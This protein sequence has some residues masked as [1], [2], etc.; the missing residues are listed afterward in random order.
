MDD[1]YINYLN[2]DSSNRVM[3]YLSK[4]MIYQNQHVIVKNDGYYIF[5]KAL[6]DAVKLSHQLDL[7][8][9]VRKAKDS[10]VAKY[11]ENHRKAQKLME[12]TQ[13]IANDLKLG[14]EFRFAVYT[15]DQRKLYFFYKAE[16]RI[17]FREL[18][19]I[20]RNIYKSE[21]TLVH[22]D[23]RQYV[24]YYGAIESCGLVTCCSN[25]LDKFPTIDYEML[26]DQNLVNDERLI[27]VC[28]NLKCCI[29]YEN[30]IYQDQKKLLPKLGSKVI[31]HGETYKV[32][33]VS[34]LKKMIKIRNQERSLFIEVSQVSSDASN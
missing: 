27:G 31:Y 5:A 25:F 8:Y 6:K 20:L 30:D 26:K 24:K 23:K 15:F 13:N 28:G 10:D 11:F 34:H 12:K 9:I 21:V 18:I 33:A 16:E 14:I 19:K 32:I 3:T 22:M 2:L 4:E 29:R 17:D 7:P 1:L